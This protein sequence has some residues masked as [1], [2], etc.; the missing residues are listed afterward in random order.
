LET[1]YLTAHPTDIF[2]LATTSSC[3]ISA[4]GSSSIKVYSTLSSDFPL[5]QTLEGVHKLGCHH[6]A[7]S[8]DGR[9]LVS[10]GFGGE[11]KLWKNESEDGQSQWVEDG[12]LA[13]KAGE[14]WAIS[15]S[16][17][18]QYLTSTTSDGK[19]NVFDL[20]AEGRPKIHQFETKGSFGMC[21]D[22]VSSFLISP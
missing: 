9:R 18:G 7:T 11:V 20:S 4:S 19:V 10:V 14:I 12:K 15:L 8:S 16:E 6:V 3:V 2:S 22:M 1:K 21:I 5:V 13:E 17:D